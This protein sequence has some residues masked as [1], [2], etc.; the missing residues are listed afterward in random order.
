MTELER[1]FAS[2]KTENGDDSF[3][4]TGDKRTDVLFMSQ[5]FRNHL[6]ETPYL[7]D[8]IFAMFI[9]DPRYGLG[10][11]DL[12]RLLMARANCSPE[13]VVLAGRYDDLIYVGAMTGNSSYV[14]YML[15]MAGQGDQLAKKWLPRPTSGKRS[16]ALAKAICKDF[17][18]SLKSYSAFLKG[19]KTLEVDLTN[20]NYTFDY[21]KVPS[22]A[23]TKYYKAFKR[24][25]EA[26]FDR[27]LGQVSSG[28]AKMNTSVTSPVDIYNMFYPSD[29]WGDRMVSKDAQTYWDALKHVQLGSILPIVDSSGS[30]GWGKNS[31][32]LFAHA[33]GHYV[34]QNSTYMT[35]HVVKFS[36][37]PSLIYLGTT[38]SSAITSLCSYSDV[39]RTNFG[40]VMDL[41]KG[42]KEDTPDYLLVLSDMEFDLGSRDSKDAT[43]NDFKRRGIKTRIIWWNFNGRNK[44]VPELD[45]DGNIFL[46]GYSP[47]LLKFLEAGFDSKKFLETLLENYK[48]VLDI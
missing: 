15:N 19:T 13:E 4:T 28:E 22:L 23:M 30:M 48:K 9:R 18:I 16:K 45:S 42:L 26:R 32:R 7:T 36:N 33:I 29:S 3:N 2:K 35:N 1:L 34:S 6:D 11:R 31:A 47:Q 25:D 10:E 21:S 12:G 43:M 20:K 41:L 40:G 8:K 37:H 27:Y 24:N 14:A 44:T 46:S 39:G 17:D 5:Y 38:V